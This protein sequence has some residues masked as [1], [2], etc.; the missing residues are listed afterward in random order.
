M[1][2]FGGYRR[3]PTFTDC[4]GHR[5]LWLAPRKMR[6]GTAYW[7]RTCLLRSAATSFEICRFVLDTRDRRRLM[8]NEPK[9][10]SAVLG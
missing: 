5:G 9:V 7:N 4:D 8:K 1:Q 3:Q 2:S 6:M 10:A